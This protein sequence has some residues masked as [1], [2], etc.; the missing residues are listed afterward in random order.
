MSEARNVCSRNDRTL[1]PSVC[2]CLSVYLSCS[3]YMYVFVCVY[4]YVFPC[5]WRPGQLSGIDFLSPPCWSMGSN[6]TILCDE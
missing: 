3:L 6:S 2:A 5:V 4:M 1:G